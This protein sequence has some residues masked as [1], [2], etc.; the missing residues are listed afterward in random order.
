MIS[1]PQAL[2]T[3]TPWMADKASDLLAYAQKMGVNVTLIAGARRTCAQQNADYAEGR[4]TPGPIVTEVRG[5]KSWH[6]WGRAVDLH[7]DGPIS[8]YRILGDEWKRWGGIWG[9]DFSF[10]DFGH[11]EWHPD[12]PHVSD[13]CPTGTEC[14]DPNTA[15]PDDRP[16]LSKPSVRGVL[17]VLLALGGVAAAYSLTGRRLPRLL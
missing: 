4:D 5:C 1:N 12:V 15:W 6:V 11:F 16:F 2:D 8:D 7:I 10:D 9:G 14:P 17:G 13:L 3:L